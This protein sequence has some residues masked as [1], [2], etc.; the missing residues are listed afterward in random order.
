[1]TEGSQAPRID[2][3]MADAR[4][5]W[6]AE[7][8]TGQRRAKETR[9]KDLAGSLMPLQHKYTGVHRINTVRQSGVELTRIGQRGGGCR[10]S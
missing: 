5:M 4:D 8:G 3:D 2:V 1:M 6:G 9:Y 7:G 10:G